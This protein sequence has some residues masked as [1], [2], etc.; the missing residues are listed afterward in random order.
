MNSMP[1]R[2]LKSFLKFLIG[3]QYEARKNQHVRKILWQIT[4]KPKT[5]CAARQSELPILRRCSC[6]GGRRRV[7]EALDCG[8]SGRCAASFRLRGQTAGKPPGGVSGRVRHSDHRGGLGMDASLLLFPVY[9]DYSTL[10]R[11]KQVF[12]VT[13]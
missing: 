4:R 8:S 12:L 7:N 6:C 11:K 10:D 3:I 5:S 1:F 2:Q 9:T 13:T